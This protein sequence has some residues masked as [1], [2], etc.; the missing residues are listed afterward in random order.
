MSRTGAQTLYKWLHCHSLLESRSTSI[1]DLKLLSSGL[2]VHATVNF[3]LESRFNRPEL[4]QNIEKIFNQI[5]LN[6][7]DHH[8][9]FGQSLPHRRND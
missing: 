2:P 1:L 7:G 9:R 6:P 4:I 3:T 5:L 8:S